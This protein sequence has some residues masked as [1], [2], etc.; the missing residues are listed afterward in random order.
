MEITLPDGRKFSSS[1]APGQTITPPYIPPSSV[2]SSTPSTTPSSNPS[3]N[4]LPNE[5]I[6]GGFKQSNVNTLT[7]TQQAA[8]NFLE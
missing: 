4:S 1:A 7:P 5:P 6:M 2:P 3:S 8:R